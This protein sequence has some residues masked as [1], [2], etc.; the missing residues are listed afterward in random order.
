VGTWLDQSGN[1]NHATAS[2]DSTRPTLKLAIQNARPA[3]LFDG[4]DDWIQ[5]VY[6]SDISQAGT[7]IYLV[8][9]LAAV[10]GGVAFFVEHRDDVDGNPIHAIYY[11]GSA[12]AVGR[13]RNDAGSLVDLPA[14]AANSNWTLTEYYWSGTALSLAQD[15]GTPN[16]SAAVG[17][18]TTRRLRLAAEGAGPSESGSSFANIY[19]A[20]VLFFSSALSSDNRTAVRAYLQDRWGTP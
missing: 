2:A 15:G 19:I 13:I 18:V 3:L 11:N 12:A 17:T 16:S 1:S 6:G 4:I 20:E 14:L 8:S 7:T 10:P 5:T 9:K